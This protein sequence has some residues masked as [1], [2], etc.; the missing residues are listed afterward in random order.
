MAEFPAYGGTGDT[1]R[2]EEPGA[3]CTLYNSRVVVRILFRVFAQVAELV[4]A[5]A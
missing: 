3:L 2:P 5:Q 1:H 4:Y